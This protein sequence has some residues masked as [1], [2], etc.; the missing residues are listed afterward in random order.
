MRDVLETRARYRVSTEI[1]LKGLI[2]LVSASGEA[3]IHIH[4]KS[5]EK[6]RHYPAAKK[7]PN[8]KMANWRKDSKK[9]TKVVTE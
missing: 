8:V 5:E 7:T 3:N 1:G 9:S 6:P 2:D 4:G